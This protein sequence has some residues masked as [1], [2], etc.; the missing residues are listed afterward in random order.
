MRG[1]LRSRTRLP[2]ICHGYASSVTPTAPNHLRKQ[3]S[4][5]QRWTARGATSDTS[6][7][8][9]LQATSDWAVDPMTRY[10]AGCFDSPRRDW[11]TL[12]HNFSSAP[13]R[14]NGRMSRV[15]WSKS[16][17]WGVAAEAGA[18]ARCQVRGPAPNGPSVSGLQMAH[19]AG[20]LPPKIPDEVVGSSRG[21]G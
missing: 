8:T 14:M 5:G 17:S 12:S 1:T 9:V 4:N 10:N 21:T 7:F 3:A 6:G 18:V 13:S 11:K 2:E 16:T 20:D 19:V 15:A